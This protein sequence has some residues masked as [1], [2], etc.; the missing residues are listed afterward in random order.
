M[1][2][3]VDEIIAA[4]ENYAADFGEKGSLPMPPGR[5]FAIL[6][7]MDAPGSGEICR[8]CGRGCPCHS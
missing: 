6:T 8:P 4:N 1:S 7:C 3:V 2:K 5:Q